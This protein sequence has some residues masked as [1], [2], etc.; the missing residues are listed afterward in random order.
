VADTNVSL[1]VNTATD[2]PFCSLNTAA[3]SAAHQFY[4]SVSGTNVGT[5]Q[6]ITTPAVS[7]AGTFDGDD[8][9]YTAVSGATVTALIFWRNNSGAN[10]TWRLFLFLDTSVTNLPVVPNGGNITITFAAGGI[11]TIC[12]SRVKRDVSEV[13]RLGPLPLYEYRYA[14]EPPSARHIGVM[15]QDAAAWHPAAVREIDGLLRVNYPV[16]LERVNELARSA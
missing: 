8:L 13:G 1:N 15:A 4:S 11:F 10:T 7:T 16:L 9:T 3:Y 2:G 12:D 6:R 14:W 5:A